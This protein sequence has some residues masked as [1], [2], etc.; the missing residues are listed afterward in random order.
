MLTLLVEDVTLLR[1]EQITAHVRFR[2]G[3]TTTLT[4]TLPT[5]SCE[6]RKTS[7]AV[8]TRADALLA[9]HTD[10]QV[11]ELLNRAGHT[12]GAGAVFDATAVAWIR[13]AHGLPS[14]KERLLAAGGVTGAELATRLGITPNQL[15]Y[16]ARLGQL[17]A[18]VCNDKGERIYA[19]TPEQPQPIQ[20]LLA[21]RER[22]REGSQ[23]RQPAPHVH[24]DH[25]RG[26]V[27]TALLRGPS[28]GVSPLWRAD[29][30]LA[31]DPGLPGGAGVPRAD[32]GQQGPAR[33]RRQL[34]SRGPRGGRHEHVRPTTSRSPSRAP[35][36]RRSE[37]WG[38]Q[39][40]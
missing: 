2:G 14:L 27:G 1:G 30:A 6:K 12:T 25:A 7:A 17:V 34:T 9:R 23:A 40:A 28:P 5:M 22:L 24:A 37:P 4:V 8:V 38:A 20:R 31:G 32:E 26:A 11:A 16:K 10:G 29:A 36:R 19:T 39:T 13:K 21:S 35:K 18:T 3:A 15:R 33:R